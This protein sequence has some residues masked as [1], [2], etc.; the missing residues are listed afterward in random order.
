MADS[1]F[2]SANAQNLATTEARRY[3]IAFGSTVARNYVG[4]TAT[5]RAT[6]GAS[7]QRR[8]AQR[9]DLGHLKAHAH[10]RAAAV[11]FAVGRV[12]GRDDGAVGELV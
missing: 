8:P 6:G 5:G 11:V 10:D 3:P 9:F 12:S 4:V 1:L 2:G 7:T